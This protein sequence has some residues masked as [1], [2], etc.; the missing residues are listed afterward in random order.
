MVVAKAFLHDRDFDYWSPNS[1]S[2]PLVS[3]TGNAS[4]D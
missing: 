2:V 4:Q 1:S 3:F